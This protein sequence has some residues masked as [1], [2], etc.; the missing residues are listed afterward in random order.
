M[1]LY[2]V[3]EIASWGS[4]SFFVSEV[5]VV[6]LEFQGFG[7]AD[8]CKAVLVAHFFQRFY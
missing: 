4:V 7:K 8:Y 6:I 5:F 3:D 2:Y 1:S